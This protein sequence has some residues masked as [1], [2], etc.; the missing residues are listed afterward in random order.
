VVHDL[1]RRGELHRWR[2]PGLTAHA[3]SSLTGSAG[4][5]PQGRPPDRQAHDLL[6]TRP[7]RILVAL[8]RP[9][10]NS[11]TRAV[12]P[13]N[14]VITGRVPW[15]C[16]PFSRLRRA[17][18]RRRHVSTVCASRRYGRRCRRPASA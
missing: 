7:P 3:S 6:P 15:S 9:L 18:K 10:P 4:G 14:P 17:R 13:I 12:R 5:R 1:G 2:D 8:A 16:V 11:S